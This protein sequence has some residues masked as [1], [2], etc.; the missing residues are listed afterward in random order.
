M[1]SFVASARAFRN[2]SRSSSEIHSCSHSTGMSATETLRG[3]LSFTFTTPSVE[4]M[5]PTPWW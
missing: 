1:G 5:T 4:P 3:A 2:P